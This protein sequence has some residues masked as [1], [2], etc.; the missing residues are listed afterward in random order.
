M[1]PWEELDGRLED[2]RALPSP[3]ELRR[4]RIDA[5]VSAAEVAEVLGVSRQ[6]VLN[7]ESGSAKPNRA[8]LR[9]FLMFIRRF[10]Q[11]P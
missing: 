1:N 7:W 11:G 2:R 10:Y 9:S 6:T 4:L 5:G 8:N 3:K